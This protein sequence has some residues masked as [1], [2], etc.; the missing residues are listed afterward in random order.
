LESL[1]GESKSTLPPP[2]AP[3]EGMTVRI[4][5]LSQIRVDASN[6]L[7]AVEVLRRWLP[8]G[9]TVSAVPANNALHILTTATAHQAASEFLATLD[10]PPAV[11]SQVIDP[12]L[13]EAIEKFSEVSSQPQEMRRILDDF[14]G[15]MN[16]NFKSAQAAN[17]EKQDHQQRRW[18][19]LTSGIA[20]ATLLLVLVIVIML[21]RRRPTV[22]TELALAP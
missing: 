20:S 6:G 2:S 21:S 1:L 9:S 12:H 13:K 15:R 17:V 3:Q 22:S 5:Q 14:T 8:A 11:S 16:Q 10:Q 4:Y 7:R 18:F 19:Y